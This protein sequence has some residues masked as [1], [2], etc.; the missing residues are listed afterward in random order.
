M[1]VRRSDWKDKK[2]TGKGAC[3]LDIKGYHPVR[4]CDKI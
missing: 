2:R 1:F 4:V 3:V